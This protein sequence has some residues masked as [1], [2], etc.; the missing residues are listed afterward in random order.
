M[1]IILNPSADYNRQCKEALEDVPDK[2]AL[3]CL[4]LPSY[5]TEVNRCAYRG[6][7]PTPEVAVTPKPDSKPLVTASFSQI[8]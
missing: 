3:E 1:N 6:T 4:P 7:P 2:T 5:V 8:T